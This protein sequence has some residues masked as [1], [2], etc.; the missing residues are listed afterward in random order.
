MSTHQIT[1]NASQVMVEQ[2]VASGIDYVF[3]NSGSREAR[4]FDSLHAN[5]DIQGILSLHE[6]IVTSAAGG[7]TQVKGDPAVIVVHLGAGL[8]QCLGQLINVW[9]ASLPVVVI[10]F[11]GDTGSFADR[12]ELDLSH[13]FG[14]TSIAAPFVKASWAVIEPEGLPQALRRAIRVAKTPPFGP[15]HLAVYDRLLE[16]DIVTTNIIDGDIQELKV[17]YPSDD[18][19]QTISSALDDAERPMFFVGDGVWKSNAEK[20]LIALAEHYGAAVTTT[21]FGDARGVPVSHQLHCGRI[22]TAVERIKPDQIICFGVRHRG[23]GKADD[24]DAF[25]TATNIIAVG[26]GVSNFQNLPGVSLEVLADEGRTI[27]RLLEV[28]TTSTPSSNYDARRAAAEAHSKALR[29]ER[30]LVTGWAPKQSGKVRPLVLLDTLDEEL[31]LLGG[32]VV[33]FES[34][35]TSFDSVQSKEGGGNNIYIRSAGGSEGYGIGAAIG[36]KLASPDTPVVG[37]VGD[38]STFYADSG[39]WTAVHHRIPVLYVIPNNG[40][41]GVV[42]GAFGQ[43]GEVMIDTGQYASVALEGIEPVAIAGGFG[44]DG[45]VVNDEA[46]L[47]GAIKHGLDVVMNDQLP[48]LIDV[49]LPLGLPEGGTPAEVW[50]LGG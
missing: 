43:A 4:F 10:T 50:K 16:D 37:L 30:R 3:Y 14:P 25:A 2:L 29:E 36:A 11:A 8:A 18:D 9:S 40:T 44:M 28:A 46:K 35:S 41:Y 5:P 24:F 7:Y 26:S 31:E 12:I 33:T 48:Y 13:T 15:V 19:V 45:I 1:A 32:G 27:D 34:P 39:L 23:N 42:A 38:G 17:G 6:G 21:P 20:E 49:K 22:D 47:R